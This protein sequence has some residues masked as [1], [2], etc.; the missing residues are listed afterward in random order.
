MQSS[1]KP[2]RS[3]NQIAGGSNENSFMNSHIETHGN[4]GIGSGMDFYGQEGGDYQNENVL[5]FT[6]KSSNSNSSSGSK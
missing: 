1:F 2:I 4:A 6:G 3:S 5:G